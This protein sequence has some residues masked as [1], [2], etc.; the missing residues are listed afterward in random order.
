MGIGAWFQRVTRTRWVLPLV[1][2]VAAIL[3]AS[4][5]WFLVMRSATLSAAF[6]LDA[7]KSALTIGTGLVLGGAL[8]FVLDSHT[9]ARGARDRATARRADQLMG[10]RTVHDRVEGARL[11]IPAHRSAETYGELMRDL[12]DGQVTL[13]DIRRS[14][15]AEPKGR[16]DPAMA[17]AFSE[18]VG[19]LQAL[20][21]EYRHHYKDASDAQRFDDELTDQDFRRVAAEKL[22]MMQAGADGP[23]GAAT[24]DVPVLA[25]APDADVAADGE[26][27]TDP[28]ARAGVPRSSGRA[29]AL[30]QDPHVFPVLHDFCSRGPAYR[31]YFVDP[32]H[33]VV[34]AFLVDP[35]A[36]PPRGDHKAED[37]RFAQHTHDTSKDV[38]A[39]CVRLAEAGSPT[40]ASPVPSAQPRP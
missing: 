4:F 27:A 24:T 5:G 39:A 28:R 3:I 34:R 18:M 12:I 40:P 33:A 15:A 21:D 16:W 25:S 19:Y 31:R 29:W 23:G 1:F 17:D 32:Y 2:V 38:T 30:L 22:R 6:R 37:A 36:P 10:L 7:A 35:S 8:K 11:L 14:L 13:L 26:R 9:D 20:H